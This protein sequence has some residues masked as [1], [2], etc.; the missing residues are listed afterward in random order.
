MSLRK[1]NIKKSKPRLSD[2]VK[3]CVLRATHSIALVQVSTVDCGQFISGAL[4]LPVTVM[5]H[6]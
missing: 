2:N 5:A 3:T 4:C 1:G 6:Y